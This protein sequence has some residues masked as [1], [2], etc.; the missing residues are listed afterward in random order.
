MFGECV[1]LAVRLRRGIVERIL[2]PGRAWVRD[3]ADCRGFDCNVLRLTAA[4]PSDLR[5][6][7]EVIFLA[8]GT[9]DERGYIVGVIDGGPTAEVSPSTDARVEVD[10]EPSVV[11][12][13]ARQRLELTCG[14]A[15][16]TMNA[17]GTVVLKG[18]TVISRASGVNKIRGAAVRIN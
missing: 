6:G 2:E 7:L 9:D 15:S 4:P 18:T 10:G 3:A 5:V 13:H 17:D 16:L 12:L 14:R 1:E 8:D 11:R